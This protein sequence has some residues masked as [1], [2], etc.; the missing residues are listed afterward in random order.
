[1]S[2]K[3]YQLNGKTY[4]FILVLKTDESTVFYFHICLKHTSLL[5]RSILFATK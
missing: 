3:I 1:M 2:D 5:F 4:E